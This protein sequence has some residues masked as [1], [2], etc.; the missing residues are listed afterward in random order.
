MFSGTTSSSSSSSAFRFAPEIA[1]LVAGAGATCVVE[2]G[3]DREGHEGGC[4]HWRPVMRSASAA[5]SMSGGPGGGS[6]RT[7]AGSATA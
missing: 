7:G 1:G 2:A 5:F 6:S 3:L 4:A